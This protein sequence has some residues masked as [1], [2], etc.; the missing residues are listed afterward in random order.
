MTP[1]HIIIL[2]KPRYS[3]ILSGSRFN[4]RFFVACPY[5]GN[6]F[7][8]TACLRQSP[9]FPKVGNGFFAFLSELFYVVKKISKIS[10]TENEI[11]LA[12]LKRVQTHDLN[13]F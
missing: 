6:H 5:R 11:H 8:K 9:V 13:F 4:L 12:P 7:R 2:R 1:Q 3:P 10:K